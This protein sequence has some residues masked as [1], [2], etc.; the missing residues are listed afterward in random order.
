MV[1]PLW[2]IIPD[3]IVKGDSIGHLVCEVESLTPKYKQHP[4]A[5]K[6]KDRN[7]RY[8]YVHVIKMENSLGK[9]IDS[10]KFEVHHK[11][12]NPADNRLSNLELV[13]KA[14]HAQGH[15][16]K[17]K[18]WKKSPRNKPGREAAYRVAGQFLN[19]SQSF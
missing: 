9:V 16:F 2:K 11:N 18:F 5:L 17:K 6:L 4:N 10:S 7:K 3:S 13:S 14:D 19:I 15:S 8:V 1:K 12:E